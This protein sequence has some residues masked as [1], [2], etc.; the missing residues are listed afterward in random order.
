MSS[1]EKHRKIPYQVV[2]QTVLKLTRVNNTRFGRKRA[3]TAERKVHRGDQQMI[4]LYLARY[5][6]TEEMFSRRAVRNARAELL[7]PSKL[8]TPISWSCIRAHQQSNKQRERAG[9]KTGN[10]ESER[11]ISM[12]E[13]RALVVARVVDVRGR[14]ASSSLGQGKGWAT[15]KRERAARQAQMSNCLYLSRSTFR[16]F[17]VLCERSA[18]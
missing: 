4:S 1:I 6:E 15:C 17:I 13:T 16:I 3:R 12:P 2:N 10:T 9:R 18:K 7:C 5:R 14:A 8:N 11:D